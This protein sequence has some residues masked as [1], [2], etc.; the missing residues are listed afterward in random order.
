MKINKRHLAKTISWRVIGT[1]DTFF[2]AW[3][4]SGDSLKGVSISAYSTITKMI[5]YYF[6][7]KIWSKSQ[8]ESS[9]KRH[10][11]KTFTWRFIGTLDTIIISWIVLG[12]I[13]VGLQIGVAEIV[14]KMVLYYFHEKLWYKFNFG[15]LK[16]KKKKL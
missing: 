8:I 16:S 6:H 7:E 10:V 12:D 1:I 3:L 5:W 4:F 9:N 2:F 15:L 14:T 13:S 11:Y